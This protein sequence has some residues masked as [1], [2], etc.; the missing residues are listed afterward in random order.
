MPQNKSKTA[1]T[2]INLLSVVLFEEI[3][4]LKT[5]PKATPMTKQMS[6]LHNGQ[7]ISAKLK[8]LPFDTPTK[9]EMEMVYRSR[10]ITVSMATTSKSILT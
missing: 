10:E 9:I 5:K 4:N 1:T 2:I 6:I 7:A 3:K 8:A